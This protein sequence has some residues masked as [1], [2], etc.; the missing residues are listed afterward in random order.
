[1]VKR[2]L[3]KNFFSSYPP[4][5]T[6]KYNNFEKKYIIKNQHVYGWLKTID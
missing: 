1:M 2:D 5:K 4:I 3:I 6:C